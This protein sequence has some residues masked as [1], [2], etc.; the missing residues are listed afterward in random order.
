MSRKQMFI[1]KTWTHLGGV[2]MALEYAP[3]EP[4]TAFLFEGFTGS[5]SRQCKNYSRIGHYCIR[6]AFVGSFLEEVEVVLSHLHIDL[7]GSFHALLY[8]IIYIEQQHY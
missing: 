6:P 8:L 2:D 3:P 7:Q 4:L 1:E 5:D